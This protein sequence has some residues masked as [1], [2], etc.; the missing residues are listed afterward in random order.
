MTDTPPD[1]SDLTASDVELRD[2]HS[3]AGGPGKFE[4]ET[5][6][7]VTSYLYDMTLVDCSEV[8]GDATMG[9]AWYGLL[10]LGALERHDVMVLG[11]RPDADAAPESVPVAAIVREDS[12]GFITA[13]VYDS[14]DAAQADWDVAQAECEDMA[15]DGPQ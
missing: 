8:C 4:C 10:Y 6:P 14:E 9:P 13:T 12:Q 2:I 5:W 3:G 7:M 1:G 11:W 15:E